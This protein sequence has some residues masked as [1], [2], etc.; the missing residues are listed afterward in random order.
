MK[1][2]YGF[3]IRNRLFMEELKR[4]LK[5]IGI[6]YEASE[7]YQGYHIEILATPDEA[8]KIDDWLMVNS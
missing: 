7:C 2:F 6:Y 1:K 4:H 5:S 8:E 3:S